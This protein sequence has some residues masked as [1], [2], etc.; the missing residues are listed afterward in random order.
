MTRLVEC[1]RGLAWRSDFWAFSG[2][3]ADAADAA[4][5]RHSQLGSRRA[6]VA[7]AQSCSEAFGCCPEFGCY[8]SVLL[9]LPCISVLMSPHDVSSNSECL[10]GMQLILPEYFLEFVT[11][12]Q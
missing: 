4:N 9:L 6:P 10:V 8:V 3:G 2:S 1:R 11:L 5:D 12:S 7:Q